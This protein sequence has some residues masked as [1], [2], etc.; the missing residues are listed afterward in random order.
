MDSNH[1]QDTRSNIISAIGTI[2]NQKFLAA[3]KTQLDHFQMCSA[4]FTIYDFLRKYNLQN[5]NTLTHIIEQGDMTIV[6]QN[7]KSY[8]ALLIDIVREVIKDQSIPF[9]D[10]VLK[11]LFIIPLSFIKQLYTA[12]P[13]KFEE[14]MFF[15][16]NDFIEPANRSFL[17]SVYN[18]CISNYLTI[19]SLPNVLHAIYYDDQNPNIVSCYHSSSIDNIQAIESDEIFWFDFVVS[20]PFFLERLYNSYNIDMD[21][22][23]EL[24]KYFIEKKNVKALKLIECIMIK[25]LMNELCVKVELRHKKNITE[26]GLCTVGN[27]LV[28]KHKIDFFS[29]LKSLYK[30]NITLEQTFTVLNRLA[31]NQIIDSFARLKYQNEKNIQR[32]KNIAFEKLTNKWLARF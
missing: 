30:Q 12:Y 4:V 23:V 20:N 15:R 1:T 22:C 9:S 7:N 24:E 10:V 11:K 19:Q 26:S 21:F 17:N 13:E 5:L 28:K 16:V 2:D 25:T 3:I 31:K 27:K 29:Q 8:P 32:E 14:Y 6:D 18:Y